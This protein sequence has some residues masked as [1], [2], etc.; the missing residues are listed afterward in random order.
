[1]A[2]YEFHRRS[3]DQPPTFR[4]VKG[5]DGKEMK[6]ATDPY[7][8]GDFDRYDVLPPFCGP[9][10]YNGVNADMQPTE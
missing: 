3:P 10:D 6:I 1:M 8:V 7:F 2:Q 9:H 5:P 4:V